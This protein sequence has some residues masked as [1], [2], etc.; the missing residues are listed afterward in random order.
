MA[1]IE[2]KSVT[3]KKVEQLQKIGRVTFF[4]TLSNANTGENPRAIRLY[5]KNGFIDSD[6]HIFK[7]KIIVYCNEIF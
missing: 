4:E 7:F 1:E 2:I 6:K 5:K 3:L